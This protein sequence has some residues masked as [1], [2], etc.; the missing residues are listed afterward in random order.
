MK[1]EIDKRRIWE[2]FKRWE[3]GPAPAVTRTPIIAILA[4][5]H[6]NILRPLPHFNLCATSIEATDSYLYTSSGTNTGLDKAQLLPIWA[7]TKLR[8]METSASLMHHAAASPFPTLS[9]PS[10][11]PPSK[12]SCGV[13][14]ARKSLP[15]NLAFRFIRFVRCAGASF[16]V[17]SFHRKCF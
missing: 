17:I 15:G 7:N 9:R 11:W 5:R 4:K 14:L 16:D 10:D 1:N 2:S 13:L 3:S 12:F 6:S 8:T